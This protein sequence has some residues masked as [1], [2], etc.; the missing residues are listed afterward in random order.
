MEI[1]FIGAAREVTGSCHL[2]R[3]GGATVLVDCGLIQGRVIDEARNRD[4]FPFDA[5]RIDAVVLSHAHL[6]HSGRLPLLVKAGFT[7]P[8]YAQR[9]TRDL[10]RIMLKD[11]AHLNEKDVE[12]DNRKRQRK[13]LKLL[14]P[15]YTISEADAAVKQF[16]VL[17]YGVR[18]RIAP[19]AH[20]RP[21]S[22]RFHREHADRRAVH[23]IR[24]ARQAGGVELLGDMVSA[25][26]RRAARASGGGGTL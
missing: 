9:A 11:A 19:G 6:D 1:Q 4:P 20:R 22:A 15:L 12:W 26:S 16:K 7:G 5:A 10:C 21:P 18:R 8:I 13:G 17:D 14:E 23:A 2:L 24:V 25:L 3:V